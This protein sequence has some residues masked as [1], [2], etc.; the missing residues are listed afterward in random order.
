M[1]IPSMLTWPQGNVPGCQ[2]GPFA[3][4]SLRFRRQVLFFLVEGAGFR[5]KILV[6]SEE[7]LSLLRG[8]GIGAFTV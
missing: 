6:F 2:L 1:L 5:F 8:Q 7:G 4:R 3:L